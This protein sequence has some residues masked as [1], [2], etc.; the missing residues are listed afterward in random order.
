MYCLRSSPCFTRIGLD[1]LLLAITEQDWFECRDMHLLLLFSHYNYVF[2]SCISMQFNFVCS[3]LFSIKYVLKHRLQNIIKVIIISHRRLYLYL[4]CMQK[5]LYI[6]IL[7][8]TLCI[9]NNKLIEYFHTKIDD[10]MIVRT[11]W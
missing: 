10:Y 2:N 6:I 11:S 7:L 3:V 9:N 5:L 8:L 4:C 1:F